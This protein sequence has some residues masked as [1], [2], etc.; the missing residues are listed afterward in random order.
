MT[1]PQQSTQPCRLSWV[2]TIPP[3]RGVAQP[4][5]L[6]NRQKFDRGWA[7][8][9]IRLKIEVHSKASQLSIGRAVSEFK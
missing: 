3:E 8:N 9:Q 1:I 4:Y 5:D 2:G 7:A 6:G